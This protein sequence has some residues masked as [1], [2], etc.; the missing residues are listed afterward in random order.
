MR[1]HQ[2]LGD[3][4]HAVRSPPRTTATARAV[5]VWNVDGIGSGTAMLRLEGGGGDNAFVVRLYG[6]PEAGTSV[7]LFGISLEV[8]VVPFELHSKVALFRVVGDG[9][10]VSA[11]GDAETPLGDLCTPRSASPAPSPEPP[12]ALVRLVEPYKE[13]LV[14]HLLFQLRVLV[15][16]LLKGDSGFFQLC[17][18]RV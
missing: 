1:A 2:G 18:G 14:E 16:F 7:H 6:W 9:D 8:H 4:S 5:V 13:V 11:L 15:A 3:A 17:G 10:G 12:V